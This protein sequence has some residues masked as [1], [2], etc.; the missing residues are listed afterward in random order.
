MHPARKHQPQG[1]SG[2][3][4]LTVLLVVGPLQALHFLED[5]IRF[6]SVTVLP[7]AEIPRKRKADEYRQDREGCDEFDERKAAAVQR[8]AWRNRRSSG[9]RFFNRGCGVAVVPGI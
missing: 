1:V 4:E 3:I 8:P 6:G 9:D 5:V 7:L 2:G